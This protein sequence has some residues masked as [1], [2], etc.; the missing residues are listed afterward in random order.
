MKEGLKERRAAVVDETV[1][2]GKS[3]RGPRRSFANYKTTMN[4]LR[5]PDR[6]V[7]IIL[8]KGQRRR[9][10][11]YTAPSVLVSE[12]RHAVMSMKVLNYSR[13]TCRHAKCPPRG[14]RKTVS[15]YKM[16]IPTTLATIVQSACCL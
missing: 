8:L 14:G 9:Q 16:G 2:T 4:S 13:D 10:D 6:T 3:I 15:L 11:E 5:R 1:E 12:I 7:T